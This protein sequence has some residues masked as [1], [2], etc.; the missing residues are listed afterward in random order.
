MQL[1]R[2]SGELAV[3]G[4]F[5]SAP[6]RREPLYFRCTLDSHGID[7]PHPAPRRS[8]RHPTPQACDPTRYTATVRRELA[9]QCQRVLAELQALLLRIPRDGRALTGGKEASIQ[10]TGILWSACDDVVKLTKRGP[11]GIF[12]DKTRQWEDMLKDVLEELKEWGEDEADD[13]DSDESGENGD[14][15]GLADRLGDAKLSAQDMIDDLMDS[16]QSI[17]RDDPDHIRPRL[18]STMKRLRLVTLL[19][20]AARVRRFNRLPALPPAPAQS[21]LPRR[22]D[23]LARALQKLPESFEDLA[24]AFYELDADEVD[25]AMR[26]CFGDALAISE[27][28]A[29]DWTGADDAFSQWVQRFQAEIKLPA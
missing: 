14:V 4:K 29:K 25:A 17:P 20:G 19:Y 7:A 6:L 8:L 26:A 16:H 3:S 24:A 22:L 27:L 11:A 5:F 2:Q 9:Q 23:E 10:V 18:E 21:E 13:S 28:L 1:K 15:D 12:A